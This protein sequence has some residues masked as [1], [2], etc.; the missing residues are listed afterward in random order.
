VTLIGPDGAY[1]LVLDGHAGDAPLLRGL[2]RADVEV[3]LL[4]LAVIAP[5]DRVAFVRQLFCG[6]EQ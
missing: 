5:A 1:D 4:K 6:A 2:S 3:L